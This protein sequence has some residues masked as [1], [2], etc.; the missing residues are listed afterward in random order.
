MNTMSKEDSVLQLTTDIKIH[1][2]SIIKMEK[3][4][5]LRPEKAF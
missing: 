3:Y 5:K 4:G 2:L 1:Y